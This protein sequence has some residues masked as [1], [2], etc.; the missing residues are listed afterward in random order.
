[1]ADKEV[2]ESLSEKRRKILRKGD[3]VGLIIQRPLQLSLTSPRKERDIGRRRKITNGHRARYVS[4]RTQITSPFPT[5]RRL[6]VNRSSTND[7]PQNKEPPRTNVR[8]SI[9][10]RVVPPGVSSSSGRHRLDNHSTILHRRSQTISSDMMLLD[11]NASVRAESPWMAAKTLAAI[12][13]S[14]D[15]H[16]R[17]HKQ[18]FN[19]SNPFSTYGQR[20][21]DH[22]P[23]VAKHSAN[24]WTGKDAETASE[25][26]GKNQNPFRYPNNLEPY[27]NTY[28]YGITTTPENHNLRSGPLIFSS[29]TTSIHHPAPQSSKV[30][31][32]LRPASSDIT[33]SN[34]AKFNG[35]N[36]I[37]SS[38]QVLE[39]EI[40]ETWITPKQNF[41]CS[42][43]IEQ[44]SF[45]HVPSSPGVGSDHALW[46]VGS[47]AEDIEGEDSFVVQRSS[48][49]EQATCSEISD[50]LTPLSP[51]LTRFEFEEGEDGAGKARQTIFPAN[52]EYPK[53]IPSARPRNF[54]IDEN[55]NE[56]W[57][58]FLFGG[59]SDETDAYPPS[60]ERIVMPSQKTGLLGTSI[61]EE[62]S[63]DKFAISD[64][65]PPH[66][67]ITTPVPPS[68]LARGNSKIT[69]ASTCPSGSRHRESQSERGGTVDFR[70]WKAS[71]SVQAEK[72]SVVIS[73]ANS[74]LSSLAVQPESQF[75]ASEVVVTANMYRARKYATF[76]RPKPFIGCKAKLGSTDQ[77]EPLH[78]RPGLRE[79]D[80]NFERGRKRKRGMGYLAGSDEQDGQ[81]DVES[82]ED[83]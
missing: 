43:Y 35:N 76:T 72:G 16:Q 63:G 22:I 52:E 57:T 3:W 36:L 41:D 6:L 12:R 71:V 46:Y 83:D 82:I 77:S 19:F 49:E 69:E 4:K 39:N 64:L 34:M 29:S 24:G 58:K 74:V 50:E 68:P 25:P 5:K 59:M 42:D 33:E 53:D 8:I 55:Q 2:E 60:P 37:M 48:L 38:S 70:K 7:G 78:I 75:S 62:A 40:W 26:E 44:G 11:S 14:M 79:E 66:Q 73:S 1:M 23:Y 18:D 9:G 47:G 45:H 27:P 20:Q 31:V 13:N 61:F 51:G 67:H 81:G 28:H 17:L 32:L 54:S 21:G 10:N 80:E 30:S 56:S 65:S 15:C